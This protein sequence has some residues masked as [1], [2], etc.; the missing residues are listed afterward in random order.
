MS[1]DVEVQRGVRQKCTLSPKIFNIYSEFSFKEDVDGIDG[2]TQVTSIRF[3]DDTVVIAANQEDLQL[4][5]NKVTG[6]GDRYVLKLNISKTKFKVGS[7]K[8]IQ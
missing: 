8:P 5:I 4:F 6:T 3:A 1:E 2:G 7:K